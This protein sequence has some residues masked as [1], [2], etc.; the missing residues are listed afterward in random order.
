[1]KA[2]EGWLAICCICF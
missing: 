1:M 2:C